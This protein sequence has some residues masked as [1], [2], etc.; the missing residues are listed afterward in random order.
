LEVA[1]KEAR[2]FWMGKVMAQSSFCICVVF[3][4]PPSSLADLGHD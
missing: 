1:V 3:Q 2:A 4:K